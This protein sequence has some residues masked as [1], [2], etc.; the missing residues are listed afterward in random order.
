MNGSNPFPP[1]VLPMTDAVTPAPAQSLFARIIG[2]ILSPKA[3]F[4]SVVAHPRPIGVLAVCALVI[5]LAAGLPQFTE[6]GRQA[7][8]DSQ[9]E[10]QERMTGQPVTDE[11]YQALAKMSSFGA[12]SAIVGTFVTM[13]IVS[14]IMAAIYFVI[15]NAILGGSGTF[16]QVLAI[17]THSQ[18]IGALGAALGA[19]IMLMQG[20]MSMSGPFNLGAL[21]PMLDETSL[22]AR[23]LGATSVF[24][25]WGIV[26]TAIGFATLYRR[27]TANIAIALLVAYLV[28]VT[29]ILAVVGSFMGSR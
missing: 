13:P 2:I 19:P 16:K 3:T 14:L 1:K 18:V 9:V 7:A 28:L 23:V 20:T 27:K 11:Q 12:Y 17:V 29:A 10:M 26:V 22:F 15:F 5:G 25:L 4:E 24:T 21:V 6:R 8:I